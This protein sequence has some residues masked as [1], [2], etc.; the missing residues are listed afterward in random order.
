MHHVC[1]PMQAEVGRHE[2]SS[3]LD[4][5]EGPG[6]DSLAPLVEGAAAMLMPGGVMAL[7]VGQWSGR[8]GT[9]APA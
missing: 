2:P 1:M 4:G 3:A 5:G 9:I 6:L 7:E 8:G